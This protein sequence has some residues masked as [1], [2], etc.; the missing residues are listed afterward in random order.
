MIGYVGGEIL[1]RIRGKGKHVRID[2]KFSIK[3]IRDG[4]VVYEADPTTVITDVGFDALC[5]VTG[6]P[7]QPDN[8][9][10]IAIGTDNTAPAASQTALGNEVMRQQ[11]TYSHTTGTKEFTVTTTF[12]FAAAYSIWESGLF[13][14]ASGGTMLCRGVLDSAVNVESGDSLQV[15]WTIT[16]S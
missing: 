11:G 16:F 1:V 2:A 9:D 14:A 4:K 7:T 6:N 5:D 3:V 15:T 10:Y 13:N 12:D 8:F